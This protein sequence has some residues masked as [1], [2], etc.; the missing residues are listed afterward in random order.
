V[1][2]AAL[3]RLL[4]AS[5]NAQGG[6]AFEVEASD[7]AAF[8]DAFRS[9]VA[10]GRNVFL[11]NPSWKASERASLGHLLSSRDCT[12][13]GWLMIPSGGSSGGIRFARHD[14]FTVAAAVRGFQA[15]FGMERVNAVSVL[16]LHHV[17]GFMAWMRCLISGGS[18]LPWSWKEAELGNFP[19]NPGG[20]SCISL[21]PTQL[22]R[23]MESQRAVE[24]LRGFKAVLLGGGAPWHSLL[25]KAASLSLPLAPGYG[26]TETA[27]MAAAVRPGEFLAGRRGAGT[28]LP[29]ARIEV[30]DG[31]VRV[32]GSSVYRGYFPDRRTD[33][34]WL[35][36]DLGLIGPDGALEI[37]GRRDDV[38][39]T[40]GMKVSASEVEA[41]LRASGEFDDVAVVGVA[42]PEWGQSVVACHPAGTRMPSMERV[43]A[44]LG[45]L[46]A[47]KHP[48]RFAA[49]EPWPRDARGKIS[50]PLLERLASGLPPG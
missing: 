44:A 2:R 36:E 43:R 14:G 9:A 15:H 35:T 32:S 49:I 11:I 34:T 40:G 19:D 3:A 13:L 37:L 47:F 23:L 31:L 45:N 38:I 1:E 27:A 8:I 30:V 10:T 48:K 17:S 25:D 7:P 33:R 16:P 24:W 6:P 20:D 42:D 21:V 5:P 22:Q 26:A 18:F 50:R 28:A 41:S 46:A 4:G 29:H 39:V 12:D